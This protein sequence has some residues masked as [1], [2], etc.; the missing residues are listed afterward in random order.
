MKLKLSILAIIIFFTLVAFV[1]SQKNKPQNKIILY[2]QKQEYDVDKDILTA[3]GNISIKSTDFSIYAQ[4]AKYIGKEQILELQQRVKIIDKE[5][6]LL[7]EKIVFSLKE[8][9]GEANNNVHYQGK[10]ISLNSSYLKFNFKAKN[11]TAEN[12]VSFNF[13]DEENN[14]INISAKKLNFSNTTNILSAY[15]NVKINKEDSQIQGKE[16]VL[17]NNTKE[18]VIEGSAYLRNEKEENFT[19]KADTINFYFKEKGKEIIKAKGNV[20]IDKGDTT[21]AANSL[22]YSKENDT[23]IL[24]GKAR[25]TSKGNSLAGETIT[26]S[27]K[28]KSIS[29]EK[30]RIIVFPEENNQTPQENK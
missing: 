29:S 3:T 27:F 8:N 19:L 9:S 30:S 20:K 23:A 4:K 28:N 13:T 26:L 14:Q 24:K 6:M 16:V 7:A 12:N 15:D 18:M 11:F 17:N 21:A 22:D 10:G 5:N 2:A 1:F 25:A